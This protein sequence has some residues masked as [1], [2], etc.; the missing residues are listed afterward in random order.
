MT[1]VAPD[2]N[3]DIRN[4]PVENAV[5]T[6]LPQNSAASIPN[7]SKASTGVTK[8]D[9]FSEGAI[10]CV[11]EDYGVRF[12]SRSKR[13]LQIASAAQQEIASKPDKPA[14]LKLSKPLSL[15]IR[16]GS[17]AGGDGFIIKYDITAIQVALNKDRK[18][19]LV[20]K[21]RTDDGDWIDAN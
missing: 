13:S 14:V 12:S 1:A 10:G 8:L 4:R 18:A 9:E 20:E 21:F 19:L 11:S 15:E 3:D 5:P 16:Y 2:S 17:A 6:N 7:L